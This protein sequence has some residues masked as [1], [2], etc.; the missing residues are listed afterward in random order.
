MFLQTGPAET[1][2]YM[3]LG[4]AVIFSVLLIYLASFSLR[5]RN[6]RSDLELLEK[7]KRKPSRRPKKKRKTKR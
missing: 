1:T 2:S 6:L 4:F 7:P 3:I 5:S